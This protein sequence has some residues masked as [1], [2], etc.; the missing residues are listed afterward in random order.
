M[1]SFRAA[2]V[3]AAAAGF[4]LEAGLDKVARLAGQACEEG[5][6]LAVFPEAFLPGYPAGL[7][8]GPWSVTGPSRDAITSAGIGRRRSMFPGRRSIGS[9][10]SRL[11][12]RC[13]W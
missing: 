4:D 2:V 9:R 13:I 3:Q 1:G 11:R 12:T 10:G 8:S 6:E 7:L 5:A